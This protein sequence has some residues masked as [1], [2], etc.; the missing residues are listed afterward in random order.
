MT[1]L[2]VVLHRVRAIDDDRRRRVD[3]GRGLV[4]DRRRRRRLVH[5]RGW[6]GLVDDGRRSGLIHDAGSR[7]RR[8]AENAHTGDDL[9]EDREGAEPEGRVRG[10]TGDGDAG[11]K[12]CSGQR[13]SRDL[14]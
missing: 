3:H 9:V 6:S 8:A 13:D 4:D 14:S 10:A 1:V 12:E 2:A 11:E 5:D 7:D